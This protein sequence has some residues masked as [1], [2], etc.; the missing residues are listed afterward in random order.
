MNYGGMETED[1]QEFVY[2]FEDLQRDARMG[3]EISFMYKGT[4]YWI[5]HG[6]VGY[7][8]FWIANREDSWQ[9]F[10]T[11]DEF[12]KELIIDG[13]KLADILRLVQHV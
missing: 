10:D 11:A 7:S 3:R 1:N 2:T 13:R 5:G 6:A 4:N 9:E 12:F 8:A